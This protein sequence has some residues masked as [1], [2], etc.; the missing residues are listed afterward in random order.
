IGQEKKKEKPTETKHPKKR[1]KDT[2]KDTEG[3]KHEGGRSEDT[4]KG[5]Q[6]KEKQDD[7]EE[8]EQDRVK[9]DENADASDLDLIKSVWEQVLDEITR[10]GK[11]FIGALLRKVTLEKLEEGILTISL[12]KG[13]EIHRNR[14]NKEETKKYI[15]DIIA[16]FTDKNI[17]PSF[18]MEDELAVLGDANDING[19]KDPVKVLKK[20]LPGE[21]F[22]MIEIIDE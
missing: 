16:K 11:V 4:K 18:V 15:S 10:D 12:K 19:Q 21:I 9:Q 14:L 1:I 22:D 2:K 5:K 7:I 20:I 8:K 6:E 13:F 17:R 3:K